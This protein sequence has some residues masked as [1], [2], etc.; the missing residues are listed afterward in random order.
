[1]DDVDVS[2][3]EVNHDQILPKALVHKDGFDDVFLTSF[4]ARNET[5]SVLGAEL[6]RSH[7][8]YCE[9]PVSNPVQDLAVL[10]EVCRQACFVVAHE[11]FDVPLGGAEDAKFLMRELCAEF[12]DTTPFETD[13]PVDV[14]VHCEVEEAIERAGQV[15][16]LVWAFT[17]RVDDAVVG[18][19]RMAQSLMP[20]SM[21]SELRNRL[22][23]GRGLP[24]K[25]KDVDPPNPSRLDPAA[26]GRQNP[27]NVVLTAVGETDDG[28]RAVLR[29]DLRHPVMFDH[30]ADY[31]FA[32][33]QLEAARQ[34]SLVAASERLGVP[35]TDL[36]MHAVSAEYKAVAEFDLETELR[37]TFSD[38]EDTGDRQL[39]RI[40]TRQQGRTVSVF[41][42]SVRPAAA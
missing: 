29:G 27:D 38:L 26:V 15:S 6:P 31:I 21:W 35:A 13:E 25:M 7:D 3:L 40:E 23:S 32:M 22:R 36:E 33:V 19:A 42:L 12:G 8:F 14:V 28:Y 20:R 4:A 18:R 2:E 16:G 30:P 5:E 37:A 9:L 34:L 17:L 24:E 39:L 41:E 1:V 10:I 11:Q